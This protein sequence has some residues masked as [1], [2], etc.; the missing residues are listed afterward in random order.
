M[1][2]SE[3]NQATTVHTQRLEYHLKAFLDSNS[4]WAP[5]PGLESKDTAVPVPPASPNEKGKAIVVSID[6]FFD[7]FVSG[8]GNLEVEDQ[9]S[10][11]DHQVHGDM[12]S[13]P[14]SNMSQ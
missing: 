10:A 11:S 4:A 14:T 6:E 8:A 3:K 13:H 2:C 7:G 1:A 9:P 5:S 12:E